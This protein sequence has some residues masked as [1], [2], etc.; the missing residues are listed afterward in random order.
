MKNNGDLPAMP[1]EEVAQSW[2][3]RPTLHDHAGEML[4]L[5]KRVQYIEI[6]Y[7]CTGDEHA[8]VNDL[9]PEL[10]NKIEGE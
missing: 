8:L 10:I 4:E 5:L 7:N 3:N 2:N 1:P 6:G 9:I